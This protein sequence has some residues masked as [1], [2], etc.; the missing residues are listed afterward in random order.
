MSYVPKHDIAH[1]KEDQFGPSML[2]ITP[3]EMAERPHESQSYA[4]PIVLAGTFLG[5]GGYYMKQRRGLGKS[6][7]QSVMEARV[8]AQTVFLGGLTAFAIWTMIGDPKK[9]KYERR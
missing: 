4:M 1:D 6:A 2:P 7:S 5:L 3:R 8:L 9:D